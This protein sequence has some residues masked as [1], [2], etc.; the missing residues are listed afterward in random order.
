MNLCISLISSQLKYFDDNLVQCMY[1]LDSINSRDL[2]QK[3]DFFN[4][5]PRAV[6]ECPPVNSSL[7]SF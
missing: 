5:L 2:L 3:F 7:I 1:M 6:P 4:K